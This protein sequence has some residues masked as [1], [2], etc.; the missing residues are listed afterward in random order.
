MYVS[1][2]PYRISLFGGGTDYPAYYLPHGSIVVAASVA[3]YC[4]ISLRALPPFFKSHR[5]RLVYSKIET[6]QRNSDL[7]HPSARACLSELAIE[8]GLEIH[9]DGDLPARSGIGSS[10]AFTVALL[11]ALNAYLGKFISGMDLAREAIRIEQ[12]IIG[13]PVGVQDQIMSALGGLN[14]IEC[15]PGSRV[16][17][18]PLN[19]DR[20]YLEELEKWLLIGYHGAPRLSR[21]YAGPLVHGIREG[22]H[23]ELLHATKQ[24][25]F[26][27]LNLLES[28]RPVGDLGD[29]F[30]EGWRLKE[31]FSQKDEAMRSVS[32]ILQKAL[33]AGALGG[34]LMGAGGSGFLLF[35]APPHKHAE[36]RENVSEIEYWL[37][38]K[39]APAGAQ[40]WDLSGASDLVPSSHSQS[41]GSP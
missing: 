29:F 16:V 12:E 39:F 21:D 6:V 38:M 26:R 18:R 25:S 31:Q 24:L 17:V 5:T 22:T 11:A 36:I 30:L 10:S 34:K 8:D 13:E 19:V 27:A 40:V 33:R 37:P 7:D 3:R 35:L 1:R 32:E 28:R 2:A 15:G 9:Y 23:L 41:P 4:Y 14:V 20:V